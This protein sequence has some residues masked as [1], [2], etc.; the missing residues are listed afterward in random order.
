MFQ[1]YVLSFW[2][3][4]SPATEL[5]PS[6]VERVHDYIRDTSRQH[7]VQ[8][9]FTQ[10]EI[11][12]KLDKLRADLAKSYTVR[13][14]LSCSWLLYNS[15]FCHDQSLTYEEYPESYDKQAKD[16]QNED[17]ESIDNYIECIGGDVTKIVQI[18]GCDNPPKDVMS[19][20]RKV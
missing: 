19:A 3:K 20:L 18:L 8:Q 1:G 14:R 11:R 17:H 12:N 5:H 7:R 16:A 2:S 13:N 4:A 15:Y 6:A 9:F 10:D